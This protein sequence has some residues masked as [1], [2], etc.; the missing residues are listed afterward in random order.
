MGQRH[1]EAQTLNS[2]LKQVNNSIYEMLS[3]TGKRMFFPRAGIFAQSGQAKGKKFNATIGIAKEDDG[4]AMFLPSMAEL[5]K[6]KGQDVFPYAPVGG[7]KKL[8]ELW[9][10]HILFENPTLQSQLF[11]SPLVTTGISHGLYIAAKL[12]IGSDDRLI[13][14]SPYWEN[15][16]LM[17]SELLSKKIITFDMFKN[18][19]IS[20]G[21]FKE[22]L[23]GKKQK[24][25]MLL[26]FPHNPTGYTPSEN[27]V[28]QISAELLASANKNNKIVVIC[29]DA[30]A[31]LIHTDSAFKESIFSRLAGLHENILAVKLDGATKEY[32]SFGFRVGFITFSAKGITRDTCSV[33]EEKAMGTIR[34]SVSN[35]SML[36]Q[37]ILEEALQNKNAA[38]QKYS[39]DK[40]LKQRCLEV[41][42]VLDSNKEYENYFKPLPFNSG[43][44]MCI[45][46]GAGIDPEIVR[47]KLLEKYDT[48]LVRL[49]NVLRISFS[50]IAKKNIKQV[51]DNIFQ[52]CKDALK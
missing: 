51:F 2:K 27:E 25:V 33:L 22:K 21:G 19:R 32:F 52:A 14:P 4:S 12:F 42:R 31:G 26:N 38:K 23:Q 47:T 8:R 39:K 34:A 49:E 50:C 37:S 40:I 18:D 16:D 30:Y 36:S 11:S 17:F 6:I 20:I 44:F 29:D 3:E 1:F 13:I 48:G 5:V 24:I 9:K 43:Y 28:T 46:L 15:Y 7:K 10:K 41:K 45:S 35:A